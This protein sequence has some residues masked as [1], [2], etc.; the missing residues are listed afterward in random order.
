MF[1]GSR[2]HSA[3]HIF[4]KIKRTL[5]SGVSKAVELLHLLRVQILNIKNPLLIRNK[6]I[7]LFFLILLIFTNNVFASIEILFSPYNNLENEWVKII[8]KAEKHIKISAF[9]ISNPAICD[10]IVR[11]HKEGVKVIICEDKRQSSIKTDCKN[12]FIK[13]GIEVVVKKTTT[14]EHNK[15]VEVDSERAIV[16]SWNISKNAQS[17]DNFIMVLNNEPELVSKIEMAI[18]RIYERDK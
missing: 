9:G 5:F 15:I 13:E 16:G 12:R 4:S 6:I 17:Q 1:F 10:A 3:W 8:S 11:K 7:T 2:V 18:D 14:L